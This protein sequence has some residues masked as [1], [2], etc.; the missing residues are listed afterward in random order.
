MAR[1]AF[2][3][4]QADPRPASGKHHLCLASL[5]LLALAACSDGSGSAAG[6]DS[7][8]PARDTATEP[9][10]STED[11]STADAG[12]P[13]NCLERPNDLVRAPN[14]QLPCELLPPGLKR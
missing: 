4:S 6:K 11:S 1:L 10:D 9:D 12:A 2:L 3:R 13:G 5:A 8:A 7:G 14:G